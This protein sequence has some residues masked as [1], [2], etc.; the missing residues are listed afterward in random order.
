MNTEALAWLGILFCLTQS[1]TFS[2][3]N[4]A[5]LGLS[6]LQLQ[7]EA[8]SGSAAAARILELREDSNFLLTTI[9][10]GNVSVNCLLTLLSDSV[11]LG[12]GAFLFST[13]GITL[14]GEIL[15]QAYFSRNAMRVGARLVPFIK[16]YQKILYPV[17]KPTAVML[18]RWLGSEEISY[19][20]ERELREVIRQHMVADDADLETR[21]GLGAL[22]FLVMDDLPIREEG[23]PVDPRSV[24][25]LPLALDL[26]IF[27]AVESS[28]DDEF[29]A[30]VQASGRKWVIL[31]D[32]EGVP[33]LVLDAD[34]YLR[35][36]LF[37]R[38]P[39]DAYRFCH[40]PILV[41]DGSIPLGKLIRRL[42]VE[43]EDSED[44]VIDHDIV[45]LWGDERRIV[46]GS[47]LLGRLMRGIVGR[48]R[49]MSA[50][51]VS[52]SGA[53]SGGS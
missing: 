19:F 36:T 51:T 37:A 17:A 7:V 24:I 9:L 12:V 18:D 4:L 40:R 31:T 44:D 15:P 28:V 33:R 29:L 35:E 21:E 1:G 30:R 43:P 47:D 48:R 34:A 39:V 8:D 52:L 3:L 22:N 13:V 41:E 11:M 46:T 10:W 6:R 20:R 38:V 50:E 25:A 14:V 23:E 45:L 53:P 32:S 5:L 49:P 2:G 16:L 26:P 42:R 27:P